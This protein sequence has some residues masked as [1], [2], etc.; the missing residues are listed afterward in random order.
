MIP[1]PAF[2]VSSTTSKPVL[3]STNRYAALSIESMNN[4]NNNNNNNHNHN[5]CPWD[6]RHDA[7]DA[8]AAMGELSRWESGGPVWETL[9]GPSQSPARAQ[10]KVVEPAG[11]GAESPT[12][13][14]HKAAR[15]ATTRATPGPEMGIKSGPPTSEGTGQT[16][17]SAFAVQAPPDMLPVS[18]P[19][20]RSA[21]CSSISI[22]KQRDEDD[23]EATA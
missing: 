10:A 1:P 14:R 22:P 3:E 6:D 12:E 17:N 20:M 4:N 9:K 19:P 5:L 11:H 21:T 2:N 13:G 7:G 16:D 15:C 23:K 18:G 8:A